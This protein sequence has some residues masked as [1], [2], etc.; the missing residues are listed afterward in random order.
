MH[1]KKTLKSLHRRDFILLTQFK[2]EWPHGS[3]SHCAEQCTV[4]SKTSATDDWTFKENTKW[5]QTVFH[6]KTQKHRKE[7]YS[8]VWTKKISG[9][10]MVSLGKRERAAEINRHLAWLW[11][12]KCIKRAS[13]NTSCLIARCGRARVRRG[14]GGGPRYSVRKKC[15]A[16]TAWKNTYNSHTKEK[17]NPAQ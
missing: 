1:R 15:Y 13:D 6:P 14:G 7:T 8:P 4:K 11:R 2:W 12:L 17:R 10:W 5:T 3:T 16:S 9:S